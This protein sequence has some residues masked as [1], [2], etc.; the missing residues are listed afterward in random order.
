MNKPENPA[1]ARV[2]ALVMKRMGATTP[3]ELAVKMTFARAEFD[4]DRARKVRDWAA[5][6]YGPT[7]DYLMPMLSRAGLLSEEVVRAYWGPE[8]SEREL[9]AAKHASE[10]AVQI[11]QGLRLQD[12]QESAS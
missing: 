4:T 9:E 7:F 6:K 12:D 10:E 3:R 11:A 8:E 2:I 1:V 5:G